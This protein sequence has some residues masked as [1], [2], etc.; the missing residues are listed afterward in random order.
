[1]TG[2]EIRQLRQAIGLNQTEFAKLV[3]PDLSQLMISR[4]EREVVSPH[5]FYRA[6]LAQVKRNYE[7]GVYNDV[8]VL[9]FQLAPYLPKH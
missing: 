2:K 1:M 3:D 8:A 6:L 7:R 4:W 5:K 9:R